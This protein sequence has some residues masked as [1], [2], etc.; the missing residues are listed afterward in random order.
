MLRLSIPKDW[1]IH[2]KG[3]A[4]IEFTT[5][6]ETFLFAVQ[7]HTNEELKNITLLRFYSLLDYIK[8]KNKDG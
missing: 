8:S 5:T 1:N 3:N 7:E 6:F 4:E 2:N